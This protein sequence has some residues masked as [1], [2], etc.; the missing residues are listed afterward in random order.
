DWVTDVLAFRG[1]SFVPPQCRAEV[2]DI[3][4]CVSQ[5]RR[6]AESLGHS[7]LKEL[8]ILAVHGILHL[9]GWKDD[10]VSRRRRMLARQDQI[11]FSLW[12]P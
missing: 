11:L 8:L 4:I 9:C 3:F 2:L 6:Q 10:T 7:L 5:A 12:I 1:D